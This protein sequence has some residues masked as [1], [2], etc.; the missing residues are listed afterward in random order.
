MT[1]S[2]PLEA[3][4]GLTVLVRGNGLGMAGRKVAV[5]DRD[6]AGFVVAARSEQRGRAEDEMSSVGR[7]ALSGQSVGLTS[8]ARSCGPGHALDE[9]A[10]I[11]AKRYARGAVRE[12]RRAYSWPAK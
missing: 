8:S 11:F 2:C 10:V 9:G 12:A 3:G 4:E 6:V 7:E 5:V 1:L